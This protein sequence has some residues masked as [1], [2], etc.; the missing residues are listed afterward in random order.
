V[1]HTD[2]VTTT[3][4]PDLV[5][6]SRVVRGAL[7]C[8]GGLSV[9]LGGVGVIVPGLPTTVFMIIAA[10]C[11]SRCSPR[12][13]QRILDLPGIG[14][15]VAD[16]RSGLGMPLRA[17]VAAISMLVIAVLISAGF[18]LSNATVRVVVVGVGLIGVGYIAVGVPTARTVTP[19]APGDPA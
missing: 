14:R 6:K 19:A 2:E 13:E 7:F 3:S 15:S 4:A 18:V 9:A 8:I 5:A 1:T 12:F 16:Y 10:A 11:F 17:K